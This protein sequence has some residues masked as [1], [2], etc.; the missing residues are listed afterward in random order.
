MPLLPDVE[1]ILKKADYRTMRN[2]NV[3]SLLAFEN[4]SLFGLVVEYETTRSLLEGWKKAELQF[5]TSHASSLRRAD[6]KAWNG[7]SIHITSDAGSK[8]DIHSLCAIEEDFT[9]TR[10]IARAGLSSR[11]DLT[12]ALAPLLPFQNT[13]ASERRASKPDLKGRLHEWPPAA[14]DAL[15]GDAT[16]DD[17]LTLLLGAK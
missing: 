14:V 11:R 13:I 6:K 8:T 16:S 2:S 12:H 7:Y 15:E 4:D 1:L 9:S 10:K 17:I 3:P 5:L